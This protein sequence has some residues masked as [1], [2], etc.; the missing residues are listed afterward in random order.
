MNP[1]LD[2]LVKSLCV[3]SDASFGG[4]SEQQRFFILALLSTTIAYDTDYHEKQ[5]NQ[6]LINWLARTKG[7]LRTDHVELR[8]TLID[9][10][11]WQRDDGGRCYRRSRNV[12]SRFAL[13]INELDSI[14]SLKW[15]A[16]NRL[17]IQQAKQAKRD[18]FLNQ[19]KLGQVDLA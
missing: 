18:S 8:R 1:D 9:Y 10:R 7:F 13:T 14:D 11:L 17:A 5:V 16:E 3:K 12:D 4:L 6:A 19:A 15:F 2:Q